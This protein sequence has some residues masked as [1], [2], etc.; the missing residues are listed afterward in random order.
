MF[1]AAIIIF[2]RLGDAIKLEG[3]LV[4]IVVTILAI[5]YGVLKLVKTIAE[6]ILE[7]NEY[8]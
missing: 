3:G 2:Y 1:L 6:I 8:N 7:Y 4:P 5:V